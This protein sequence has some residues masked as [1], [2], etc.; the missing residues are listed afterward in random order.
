MLWFMIVQNQS[1]DF[2]VPQVINA[3]ATQKD[4]EYKGKVINRLQNISTVQKHL[5][6]CLTGNFIL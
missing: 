3:F 2:R 6:K 4:P 1:A 5:E